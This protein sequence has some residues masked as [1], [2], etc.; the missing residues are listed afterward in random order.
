MSRKSKPVLDDAKPADS[1]SPDIELLA[2]LM[3]SV[4]HIP[5]I[6]VRL[7]FDALLGLIPGVGDTVTSVVSLY[8]LHA[9]RKQ[10][11]P[12]VALA[13]MVVNV[14]LD[15]MLGS[16]PLVGDVFDVFW[17]SNERNVALMRR[18][19]TS[20][21]K[22]ARKATYGDALFL[23]GVGALMFLFILGSV[24]VAYLILSSLAS[25]L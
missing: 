24:Y 17:K 10:G 7:G 6:G 8:L 19:A 2:K 3:D 14:L 15:V 20:N 11:V 13:R 16:I 22:D 9:A 18:H 23:A 21:A 5:G 12:R 4:F 1:V 25:L